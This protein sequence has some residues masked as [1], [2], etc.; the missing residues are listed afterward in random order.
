MNNLKKA[1]ELGWIQA[2]KWAEREDLIDDIGSPTYVR[3]ADAALAD[4]QPQ[5]ED[6]KTWYDEA[7]CA[8]NEAGFA[9]VSAADTIR[10]LAR[11]L[12]ELKQPQA[13]PLESLLS[14]ATGLLIGYEDGQGV[15]KPYKP[16]SAIANFVD[17][18]VERLKDWPTTASTQQPQT[19]AV[20]DAMRYRKLRGWMSGNVKESWQ[21]VENMG[22][23]C[24]WESWDAMDEYLD[25][26][27][28]CNLGLMEKAPRKQGGA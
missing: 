13:E 18:C 2:S 9:G 14:T 22:A 4:Q 5:V 15:R 6:Y 28:E 12:A 3:E 21:E 23:L 24:A 27:S 11:E 1:Y 7:M 8:S 16:G 17:E 26:L 25:S 10:E 20:R 19:G